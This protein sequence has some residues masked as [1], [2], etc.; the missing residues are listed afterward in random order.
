ML[1]R[2]RRMPSFHVLIWVPAPEGAPVTLRRRGIPGAR[3]F[4]QGMGVRGA[5][6]GLP[7]DPACLDADPCP[8]LAG[9]FAGLAASDERERP[10]YLVVD[11]LPDVG[12]A[13]VVRLADML[14]LAVQ[15][16]LTVVITADGSLHSVRDEAAQGQLRYRL[17]A[18][19]ARQDA[20][21]SRSDRQRRA[22]EQKRDSVHL[23]TRRVPGWLRVVRDGRSWKVKVIDGRDKVV[24]RI[25]RLAAEGKGK[26]R[27]A[28]TLSRAG[29]GTFGGGAEWRPSY[30]LK[31]LTNRA[32]LGELQPMTRG[33]DGRLRPAGAALAGRFPRVV[34]DEIFERVASL[35]R[36]RALARPPRDAPPRQLLRFQVR[37]SCGAKM[38][39]VD[40]L[41]DGRADTFLVCAD[42]RE[43][44]ECA[45]DREWDAAW[46]ERKVISAAVLIDFSRALAEVREAEDGDRRQELASLL[47]GARSRRSA[48]LDAFGDDP[49]AL[50]RGRA[51]TGQAEALAAQLAG[52]A[53]GKAIGESDLAV[54]VGA[55]ARKRAANEVL[56]SLYGNGRAAGPMRR[57]VAAELRRMIDRV[58]F[59]EDAIR[60]RYGK[61]F[62][63]PGVFLFGQRPWKDIYRGERAAAAKRRTPSQEHDDEMPD[64]GDAQ[65]SSAHAS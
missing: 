45:L 59:D 20:R 2:E 6:E 8:D 56:E 13:Q 53:E 14:W 47:A 39:A 17:I 19:Y 5:P 15:A 12:E 29:I 18:A 34:D 7:L 30:V 49:E 36:E 44:V 28:E 50:R 64:V 42:A 57:R 40:Q 33:D 11:A 9:R 41:R 58:V 63:I 46:V 38:V 43:K 22:W 4:M 62:R 26:E 32:V 54:A 65:T 1:S 21:E 35:R 27:I 23:L 55:M 61:G 37:C 16:G 31:I 3:V 24:Q 10:S 60:V 52:L 25:F 48:L 51:L